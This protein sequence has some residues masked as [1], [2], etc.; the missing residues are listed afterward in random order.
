MP[1]NLSLAAANYLRVLYERV[2]IETR[3]QDL[4]RDLNRSAAS[5]SVMLGK[6]EQAGWVRHC[7][8]QAVTLTEAGRVQAAELERRHDLLERHLIGSLGYAPQVAH[9]ECERMESALSDLL[10]ARL[11]TLLERA[12]TLLPLPPTSTQNRYIVR[13]GML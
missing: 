5:V 11:E 9:A 2:S 3:V 1:N 8:Y 6:L 13:Q 12:Q 10:V 4:A 7:P